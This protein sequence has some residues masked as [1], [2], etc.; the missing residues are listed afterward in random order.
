MFERPYFVP[1]KLGMKLIEMGKYMKIKNSVSST[2][3]KYGGFFSYKDFAWGNKLFW[4]NL[5]GIV[6]H[7]D[8]MIRS[9]MGGR[10][11]SKKVYKIM[12][13]FIVE[14]NG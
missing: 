10:K 11:V 13:G 4:A 6:L 12:E 1:Q 14:V 3:P 9:C 2:P 5:W 8:L 7:R